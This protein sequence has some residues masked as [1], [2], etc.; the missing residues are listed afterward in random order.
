M[1]CAECALSEGREKEKIDVMAWEWNRK[2][3]KR[4]SDELELGTAT[5]LSESSM[6]CFRQSNCVDI[7]WMTLTKT[8]HKIPE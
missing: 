5:F 1:Q 8:S 2:K 3:G 7:A 6:R 4:G